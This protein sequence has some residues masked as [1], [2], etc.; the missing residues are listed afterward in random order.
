VHLAAGNTKCFVMFPY[1]L[2]I[3]C[4]QQAVHLA[5]GIVK[6]LNL[7]DAEFVGVLLLRILRDLLDR[8]IWKFQVVVEVHELR[9]IPTVAKFPLLRS[10]SAWPAQSQDS[11][12]A[13]GSFAS[14][15]G[16]VGRESN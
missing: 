16:W 11:L 10:S 5:V 9:H 1:G 14:L 7:P 3:G 6:E 15:A 4:L 8:L 2:R 12:S 13:P